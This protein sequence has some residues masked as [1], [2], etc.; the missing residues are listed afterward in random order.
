MPLT[1]WWNSIRITL[2]PAMLAL[3][4]T[5]FAGNDNA[6][7][8]PD[9]TVDFS[10]HYS[11]PP[12][13]ADLAK[14]ESLIRS[15][16]V[17]FCD[18]T[19]GQLRFGEVTIASTSTSEAT[20]DVWILPPGLW[21]RSSSTGFLLQDSARIF[22]TPGGQTLTTFAHEMGHAVLQLPDAYSEQ[23]R[24]GYWG[25]GWGID[26]GRCSASNTNCVEDSDCFPLEFC[27]NTHLGVS[28]PYVDEQTNTMMTSLFAPSLFPRCVDTT[29]TPPVVSNSCFSGDIDC[30]APAECRPSPY[31][32]ELLVDTAYDQFTGDGTGCPLL[33]PGSQVWIAGVLDQDSG[34]SAFNGANFNTAYATSETAG[35]FK[36]IDQIGDVGK[37][38]QGSD[39]RLGVYAQHVAQDNTWKL[40]PDVAF[41]Q[42][43]TSSR[44]RAAAKPAM[45]PTPSAASLVGATTARIPATECGV[46]SPATGKR[47]KPLST[48]YSRGPTLAAN[49]SA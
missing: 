38:W 25:I 2:V 15:A 1:P 47:R 46:R 14:M 10:V 13:A 42:A 21:N 7:I 6:R 35:A 39:H 41:G 48:S 43:P 33:N 11:Y 34:T 26:F 8:N 28:V 16:S 20:A 19:D 9:G 4:A 3:P 17:M 37:L 12:S 5:A 32:S 30:A 24:F 22:I 29:V 31:Y 23:D 18:A 27:D 44:R 40:H 49:G 36:L 45:R